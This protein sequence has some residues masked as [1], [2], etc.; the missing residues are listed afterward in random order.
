VGIRNTTRAVGVELKARLPDGAG[1]RDERGHG[2]AREHEVAGIDDAEERIDG[3]AAAAHGRLSM[4]AR[5][6][7]EVEPRP[8]ALVDGFFRCELRETG[9]Q[10]LGLRRA[11]TG[12]RPTGTVGASAH[13]RIARAK[14]R[15]DRL[16]HAEQ[17]DD[18][19][20]EHQPAIP[21]VHDRSVLRRSRPASRRRRRDGGETAGKASATPKDDVIAG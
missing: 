17:R 14:L 11:Q 2:V 12:Q 3:G 18:D 20:R 6:R 1:A 16:R 8:D 19:E 4:A 21:F 5:A 10:H 15:V 13:A 9:A 7:D